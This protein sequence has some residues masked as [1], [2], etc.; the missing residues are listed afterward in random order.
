MSFSNVIWW[1]QFE[2]S[3]EWTP[4][5]KTKFGWAVKIRSI[6]NEESTIKCVGSLIICCNPNWQITPWI[7]EPSYI[8]ISLFYQRLDFTLKSP[9]M[10]ARNGLFTITESI[11][12]SRL[13][14][15]DSK[16]S[17]HWLDEPYNEIKLHNLSLIFI[18]KLMHSCK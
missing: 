7:L 17:C 14:I 2:C 8:V 4:G 1:W 3:E 13:L 10:T 9:R 16:S 18:S 11:F 15:N 6:H 12:N 5:F